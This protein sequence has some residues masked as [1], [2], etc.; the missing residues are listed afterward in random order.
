MN[1]M[2]TVKKIRDHINSYY[3]NSDEKNLDENRS[4]FEAYNYEK[5]KQCIWYIWELID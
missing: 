2:S 1:I 4:D 5:G 3:D